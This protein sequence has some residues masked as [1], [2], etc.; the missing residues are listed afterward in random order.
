MQLVAQVV[1]LG[2]CPPLPVFQSGAL[3]V[4]NELALQR[5]FQITYLHIYSDEQRNNSVPKSSHHL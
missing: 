1:F 5:V 4:N 2:A 3:F